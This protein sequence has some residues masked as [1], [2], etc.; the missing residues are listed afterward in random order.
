ML[1]IL[2]KG[3][4]ILIG[5]K[6]LDKPGNFVTPTISEIPSDA[7]IV[8]NEVFVPILHVS[9]F[10]NLNEAIQRNNS[11]KQGLSSSLFTKD[12]TNVHKS[13]GEA[14]SDCGIVNVNI[15]TN[16]AEVN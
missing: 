5:G 9:K 4:K 16:G 3:G 10:S 6:V 14:G 12:I 1:N 7:E 11:V 2:F 15:P 13:V 8:Q